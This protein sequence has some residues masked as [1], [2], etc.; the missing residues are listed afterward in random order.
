MLP[1]LG[2]MAK[3]ATEE[4]ECPFCREKALGREGRTIIHLLSNCSQVKNITQMKIEDLWLKPEVAM[5]E[6]RKVIQEGRKRG[7]NSE[8]KHFKLF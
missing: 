5:K 3:E 2:G 1:E 4:D 7:I 6:L 8:N